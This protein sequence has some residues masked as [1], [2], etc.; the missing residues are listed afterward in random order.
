MSCGPLAPALSSCILDPLRERFLALL[1]HV[2]EHRPGCHR[3]QIEDAVVFEKLVE[4]LVFGAGYERIADAAS[5]AS[6]LRSRRN[7]WILLGPSL[8]RGRPHSTFSRG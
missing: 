6:T 8:G 3:P 2:D 7:G 1:S 4:A 5:S